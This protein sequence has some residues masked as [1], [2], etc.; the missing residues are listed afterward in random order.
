MA[1]TI[2]RGAISWSLKIRA[3][4]S[5]AGRDTRL[6][7]RAAMMHRL[8]LVAPWTASLGL[9]AAL[10]LSGVAPAPA[11]AQQ[12]RW[13]SPAVARH[14]MVVSAERNAS[15]VGLAVIR[16][17]GNAVD[18]AIA[19]HFALAVTLPY[20]G[21]LGGGGFLVFRTADGRV[22]AYDYRETAPLAATR[23]MYRRDGA[24]VDSLSVVG[25]LAAGVPG[26][27]AGMW[28]VHDRHGSL[29][30]EELLAPAIAL[31]ERGFAVD[32][33]LAAALRGDAARLGRDLAARSAFFPN[34]DTLAFGDT[35]R[36]P[37]LARTLR[38]IA[39]QGPGVFYRGEIADSIVRAT[40]AAGG[41]ITREDLARYEAKE[42]AP[43]TFDYRG[44]TVHSMAPPSSGGLTMKL[45]L[46]QLETFDM[47]RYPYPS[48][49]GLHRVVEAMRRAFAVRN[50]LMGDPD[51][52]ALPDSIR[53]EEFARRL[54]AT[55]DTLQATPSELVAFGDGAAPGGG[56]QTTHFSIVDAAGNAV[57]STTTINDWF[58]NR[59]MAAGFLLNDE[60]DDFTIAPG[61]PNQ[62]GLIQGEANAIAPGKRM[63]S[64]M[65]PTIV[66]KD[67]RLRYVL[68]TP[69]GPT[70][71]TTV[72]QIL[73]YAIDHGMTMAEAIDAKRIH[74]QHLPDV[75]RV[76]PFG[77]SEETVG[78]LTAMGH[79]IRYRGGY[80]GRAE[81]IEVGPVDGLLYARS[82]LRGGGHAAGY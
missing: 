73:L 22:S 65:T 42:R 21:N 51:F 75:V 32:P 54:A 28:L 13:W 37:G 72:A 52:V 66:E 3:P 4:R 49:A 40:R 69:G 77:L 34:G 38:L 23:D 8:P 19:T 43:V 5:F 39:S 71:I 63:L 57:A 30:W 46:D 76:E 61:V 33:T 48:A 79:E 18:A 41:I 36:Q 12:A 27:V 10:A 60:M 59:V 26:S 67:G 9:L 7:I 78:R 81:G 15:E 25:G 55:I 14:A 11:R 82:D 29:P 62:Y 31:A 44:H 1:I 50:A 58:G 64:A 24:V 6:D 68:G 74:H 17:G 35:L 2:L 70:I 20:A 80:S 16:R 47:G 56:E 45:I 53:T